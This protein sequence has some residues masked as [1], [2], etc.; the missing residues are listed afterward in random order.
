MKRWIAL[1]TALVVAMAT[2][3]EVA[4]QSNNVPEWQDPLVFGRNKLP[5]R[6]SAWPC[7]D[8]KSG[9]TSRYE[10]SSPWVRSLDGDWTFHWSP[11]PDSRPANFFT[12][13][14]DASNWK[15]IPV[16]SCWELQ[17]YGVPMYINFTYP[18]KTNP[19]SVM[20]EPPPNYTSYRQRNPI[21]SYRRYFEVPKSWH[22]R[23]VLL[24]F[25]GVGSA[26]YVWV[27]GKQVG[28][29]EDSRLPAEFDISDFIQP[30]KNLLAVEVYRFSDASY[31]EDQDM[32]RLSGIFRDV[33][34]YCTPN[35]TVW[36]SYVHAELDSTLREAAVSLTYTLRN[37]S[38]TAANG[39]SIRLTL[40]APSGRIVGGGPLLAEAAVKVEPGFN[41]PRVT[42]A[43]AVHQPLLW[44][45]ETPNVY[46]AL[47]ELLQNG[48]VIETR[49]LDI[50]FRKVEIR[51][52]QFFING[53][54][55]KVKGVNRHEFDPATGYTL[56]TERMEQDLR[57]MKQMNL[58]FVR[59][60]HY[61]D[62]PR[63]YELCNRIGL[64]VLD[65]A[66]VES[67]ELSHHKK[68]LP[69]DL[70][71]WEP[72]VVDRMRRTVIRDRNHPCVVIWSEGNEAGYGKAFLAM[73][74][75]ALAADPQHR[76]I[77]NADMNRAADIDSQTYPTPQ[78]LLQHVAGKAIRRGDAS[79]AAALL[80]QHGPYPS[81]KPFLMN[82]YAHAH[83]NSLGNFQ[84]YWDV[85]EKYPMLIGG[86]IWE[87]VD[88]TP[89]KTGPDG[90]RHFVYGGD[91]G[92]QP[93]DAAFCCKGMVTAD[94][95][96]RPHYWEAKKV[97]QYIKVRPEDIAQGRIR[98]RNNYDFTRLSAFA[99][100]WVLEEN[101]RSLRHGKLK[102]PDLAPGDEQSL[103][104]PWGKPAFRAGAEYFLTVRFRLPKDLSWADAGHI[105]AA[106]QIPVAA[107][108]EVVA[109]PGTNRAD[110][111][112]NQDG[113]GWIAEANGC[114][115]RVDSRGWLM[116]YK[117]DG[118]ECLTSPLRLNF[119][120][121]PTDND[122][123][124][125]APQL[126]AVWKDA[127]LKAEL[128]SLDGAAT[129]K[130]ACI[131][132]E[133]KLSGSSRAQVLYRLHG[134]G[135]LRI[136][137]ELKPD[138]N[139]PELPRVGVSFAIPGTWDRLR[140]FGRGPQE[141]YLDR[142]TAAFVGLY[143]STVSDW[144]THYVRPQENAN[145]TDLRWIEFTG[146]NGQGLRIKAEGQ[147]TGVSAWPY[148]AADLGEAK[149]DYEL[150][151]RDFIT[152]NVDGRQ[153][154]VG[155]DNS[156]GLPVHEEYRLPPKSKYVFAFS[157][158]PLR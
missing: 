41:E 158:S 85:I 9:W 136:D 54:S 27:N 75:A 53:R 58:N 147:P 25:A 139:G 108:A 30:G 148:S 46:D 18:F 153:M 98:L 45:A 96:P 99:G 137:V 141:N 61:P 84:D 131:A 7:P 120:R 95:I 13:N 37:A 138:P 97:Y 43:V 71:E 127:A 118:R 16:P 140:W 113:R 17:G 94:R 28:Y 68:V 51:D 47:V 125:K 67:H 150:P 90:R 65:E 154:G 101:G 49:R 119:W 34:L 10:H 24:H 110:I 62:D 20:D 23:R 73:R 44:T 134:D 69:G 80:E 42:A 156:W 114:A 126:M 8:A 36:D 78:W 87:W 92:E 57:L 40:R 128:L 21:G 59:T 93:N 66:N 12:P 122:N 52:Q 33:F 81:G 143:R 76:P 121:V 31:L 48:R 112:L 144:I 5:P 106:E 116:S 22:G 3:S 1:F 117:S 149:H 83:A 88:L 56:T 39:L 91:F 142:H 132:A 124:W 64:F 63:W 123:G 130:I 111:I 151:R 103:M 2:R 104:I 72:A 135:T 146:A 152:V 157:L 14:F 15:T 60:S 133:W 102:L 82:E 19:P 105:V 50:G 38:G 109:L 35:V 155:G 115:M 79:S 77:H 74:D 89:Y 26:M 129:G 6:N 32:W 107:P 100:E 4:A 86:L 29:S 11:D 145:R 70:P 55:I